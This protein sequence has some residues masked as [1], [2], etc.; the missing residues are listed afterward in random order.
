MEEEEWQG[1]SGRLPAQRDR[2]LSLKATFA[3]AFRSA[4]GRPAAARQPSRVAQATAESRRV[5][6]KVRVVQ[7]GADW[8]KKAASL[9][10][11]YV[12]RDGVERDGTAGTLY[13]AAGPVTR[14]EFDEP[15]PGEKH[16]F[17][18]V[19]SPE[20]ANELDL[21]TYV[22]TYMQRVE[23]DLGQ[24]L[25][26]AAVNHYN[27]DNPHAHVIIRG[28]DADGA[29][30]RMERDYVSHGLRNRAAE[31]ATQELG[32][33]PERNR[34]EQMKREA[35]LEQYTTLDRT[36]E[37]RAVAGVV[38][39]APRAA[40]DPA[41]EAA[42]KK[43]LEVLHS[44]GLAVGDEK[45][46]WKL[47]PR[48]R[49]ELHHMHRRG[50][51][52]RAIGAVLDV[53]GDRCR[54]IDRDEPKA[55]QRAE[56]ERG[57][58]GVLRWKGLDEQGQ[59]C[60]VVE[61]TGGTAYHLPIAN[62]VARDARV[63]EVVEIKR[64]VDKDERID[65]AARKAGWSYRL[66]A[67]PEYA[68]PAYRSRLEQ[69]ERMKLATR[70]GPDRWRLKENFRDALARGKPQPYWQMVAVRTEPQ[71]VDAQLTYEGYVWLDRVKLDELGH[72]G[73]GR[74]VRDALR[75]RYEYLR[76]LGLDPRGANLRWDL[77]RRQQKR[78]EQSIASRSGGVVIRPSTGFEGTVRV[79]RESNGERFLEIRS[80]AHFFVRAASARDD[81]LDGRNV[82]VQL[83]EKARISLERIERGPD[84]ER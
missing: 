71:R 11:A 75:H 79:H 42:L 25:R 54:V 60:V 28:V 41:L 49:T 43:R 50:E 2:P 9:H 21:Q 4:R 19:I 55:G 6:V 51:A 5:V 67:V 68:R 24:K 7:V 22:R 46:G 72:T 40:R 26:W 18:I 12:E 29:E 3:H 37:R 32:P 34:V 64:A 31:L 66:D 27:T 47:S 77:H 57:I 84:R 36:L 76:G 33:R 45:A 63:G 23:R 70:E 62:R 20:D 65:E 48:L 80:G 15:L 69:L 30:V 56:L 58:Q 16:Q 82:R 39:P 35:E 81:S 44:L 52:L 53:S 83:G 38:R 59:F 61:T 1:P 74:E 8:G 78:L 14:E 17:R 10:L 73:F 13:G